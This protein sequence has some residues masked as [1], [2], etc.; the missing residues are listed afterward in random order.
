[1]KFLFK[2]IIEILARLYIWRFK[3][4]IIAI[5]GNSGKTTAKEAIYAVLKDFKKVRSTAGNLNNEIG[6]PLT[7]LGDWSQEYYDKGPSLFFWFKVL[8][9][10][11]FNFIFSNDYPEVL[12]LEYGADQP[13]D[14]KKLTR[15]YKPHIS[16]VTAIGEIPVHIEY[17]KDTDD[18]AKEK[19]N[20]VKCLKSDDYAV[21]NQDDPLVLDMKN[22]TKAKIWTFGFTDSSEVKISGFDNSLD[23]KSK[24]KGVHF[25]IHKGPISFIPISINGSLGKGIALASGAATSVGLI[26]GMNLVSINEALSKMDGPKGR[27]KILS[28]IKNSTI[29]DDT[30]NSS[31]LATELSLDSLF[32]I[33]AKRKIA[34]LGDML[35]LG[36]YTIKAHQ[37]IGNIVGGKVYILV[38]V[39]PKSK[40]LGESASNQMD[41]KNIHYF[42]TSDLA[43]KK[44]QEIIKEGDLILV[45]GSQGMRMEKIIEEIMAEPQNKKKLLVRQ[46]NKWLKS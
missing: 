30:Y 1:M 43:K 46:S 32:S 40:F 23:E 22:K 25:K 44:I 39:G 18:V 27:L 28:G 2:K 31:P 4:V 37:K 10:S 26:M 14:I 42:E 35:E 20:L 24:P 3:P 12:V 17:F 19:S 13:G 29:I 33:P 6:V 41:S 34:I 7:I 9:V 36:E 8:L 45:K 16:V 15:K 5:T 21:L 11:K 38:C